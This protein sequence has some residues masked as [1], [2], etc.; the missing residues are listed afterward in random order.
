MKRL[1]AELRRRRVF[2][3]AAYYVVGAWLALQVADVVFPA[4]DIPEQSIRYLL[5]AAVLGFPVA[6]VFG[7][8]F[9]L[10]AQ[11]IH[12]TGPASVEELHSPEPL[13][14]AD[15]L[16]LG[17]LAMV[18]AAILYG[19]LGQVASV[20]EEPELPAQA[21]KARG[22]GPPVV[23]VLPFS[24]SGGSDES[25]LFARGVHDDLITQLAG[26]AGLRVISRSSLL[27][28]DGGQ[29]SLPEIG[30]ELGADAVLEAGIQVAGERM[31]LNVLLVNAHTEEDLWAE[32]YDRSLSTDN[33]FAVQSAIA[34]AIA[35]SLQATLSQSEAAELSV[36]PTQNMAAYRAYHGAMQLKEADDGKPDREGRYIAGLERAMELDEAFTGP[37]IK[38]IEL[39]AIHN[40]SRPDADQV[41]R[42][43]ALIDRIRKLKPNSVEHLTAQAYYTYYIVK[44]Y[45]IALRLLDQARRL[46][47][48]DTHLLDVKSWIHRRTGDYAGWVETIELARQIEPGNT[49]WAQRLVSALMLVHRYDDAQRELQTIEHADFVFQEVRIL[50]D[51]KDHRDLARYRNEAEAAVEQAAGNPWD[52]PFFLWEAELAMGN[53]SAARAARISADDLD[54]SDGR[55]L[56]M[57]PDGEQKAIVEALVVG[58]STAL[59]NAVSQ[60]RATVGLDA[61]WHSPDAP[62]NAQVD[63]YA[64]S[65]A[66]IAMGEDRPQDAAQILREYQRKLSGQYT[67]QMMTRQD[68]CR[69]FGLANAASAAVECLRAGIAKPSRVTPFLEPLLAYYNGIRDSEAFRELLAELQAEGWLGSVSTMSAKSAGQ[70]S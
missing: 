46:S 45:D 26:F 68:I 23:A 18:F 53:Y 58:D 2:R 19:T 28:F 55:V 5:Y 14:R 56:R 17:V 31:R 32:N 7:W 65:L 41:Q 59:E 34:A 16:L 20:R 27:E 38:L 61:G 3:T 62:D 35:S 40:F 9:D 49:L 6:L 21:A 36:L 24:T 43:E 67:A 63:V 39:L 69:L 30:R 50:L 1:F 13:R 64:P 10:S 57:L 11:G 29:Q 44:D 48:S 54:K 47:P 60:A 51:M 15:Y 33:I 37:V 12:R 52:A 8:V 66:L 70:A 22:E 25:A 42:I 4:L